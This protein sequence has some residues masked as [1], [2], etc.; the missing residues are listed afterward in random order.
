[1]TF[2][3]RFS[4]LSDEDETPFTCADYLSAYRSAGLQVAGCLEPRIAEAH[5]GAKRRA[6]R[7]IPDATI[8]AYAGLPGVL[9]WDLE[10]RLG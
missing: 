4:A 5:A 3:L 10:K 1:L 8:K 6:F 2:L 7:H 9:V